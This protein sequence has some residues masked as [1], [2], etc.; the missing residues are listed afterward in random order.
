MVLMADDITS[1]ESDDEAERRA[2]F[3]AA[4]LRYE[5][6]SVAMASCVGVKV[7]EHMLDDD[8]ARAIAEGRAQ[9]AAGQ[10]HDMGDVLDEID[11]IIDG[12]D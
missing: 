7:D 10:S 8:D 12:T 1:G 11:R 4:R 9:I 2:R 5:Q 6:A 3:A